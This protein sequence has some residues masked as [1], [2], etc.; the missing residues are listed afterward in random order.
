MFV[1]SAYGDMF[2]GS[3]YRVLRTESWC[4]VSKENG[5]ACGT[6]RSGTRGTRRR[7]TRGT[8]WPREGGYPSPA[9]PES[10]LPS[11]KARKLD[12][13]LHTHAA[14][15]TMQNTIDIFLRP[16][17]QRAV[18]NFGFGRRAT[19]ENATHERLERDLAASGTPCTVRFVTSHGIPD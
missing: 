2:V 18:R 17:P 10:S 4:K 12:E 8:T 1:G 13:S 16:A 15:Y 6:R 19:R 7:G 11:S 14:A 3:A 9:T 5:M